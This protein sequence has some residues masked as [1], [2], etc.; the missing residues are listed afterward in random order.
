LCAKIKK[1]DGLIELSGDPIKNYNKFRAFYEWPR[2]YFMKDGKRVIITDAAL[3][4]GNFL[5]KKILPEG[6]KEMP[7]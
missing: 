2:T 4:D 1:E 5:I 6:R 3:E 7:Y